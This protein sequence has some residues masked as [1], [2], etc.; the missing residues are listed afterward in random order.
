M[1]N[2]NYYE[3]LGVDKSASDDEIK[4]AYRRMAKK[5]HPD[6]NKEAGAAEKFKDVNEAYEV[7]SDKTKRSNYD[8]YGDPNGGFFGGNSGGAGFGGFSQNGFS[9]SGFGGFDFDDIFNMFGGGFGGGSTTRSSSAVRGED[10]Q[11]QINLTFKEAVLGCKK[12]ITI[13]RQEQCS[14][15]NGTGAKGGTE[16]T[17]CSTCKGT[18]IATYTENTLFGRMVRQGVCKDCN[19]TGKSIKVKCSEC[20][21]AGI[22]KVNKV[23]SINIPAGIDNHQVITVRGSGNA[24]RRGGANGDLHIIVNIK[25]HKLLERDGY[26][27]KIKIYVPFYTLIRGGEIDVPLADGY[28][29]LKIPELTQS[30]TVFKIKGKGIKNL[31]GNV[32]GDLLV[33][34][35]AESPKTLSREDK[36]ILDTLINS[37]PESSFA[38]YKSYLKDLDSVK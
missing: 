7:L 19:G 20:G 11:V 13:T 35:V 32:Y 14:S 38:R 12:D 31:N 6:I 33:T 34:I 4:S 5:Y 28:T 36:K 1:A 15:C 30:N 37:I 21:G 24:G 9:S 10:L 3:I 2:K 25:D 17:T 26:D 8:K 18:G 22:K 27:L 23:I 16:Y 29:T